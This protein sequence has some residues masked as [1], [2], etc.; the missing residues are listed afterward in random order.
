MKAVQLVKIGQPVEMHD[1]PVPEIGP[2]DVLVKVKAAGICHS[3]AHYRAGASPVRPLPMTM[4]HEVAGVVEE[5]GETVTGIQPGDRVCLH[6]M[7]T[8]GNC[9]FCNMGSEQFCTSGSMIGKYQPGGYAEP[10]MT[11]S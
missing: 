5:V 9:E 6:Y 4:G 10:S 2:K 1:I 8:C 7:I 11:L 3:D